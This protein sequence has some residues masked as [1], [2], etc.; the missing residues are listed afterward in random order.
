MSTGVQMQP[1]ERKSGEICDGSGVYDELKF[2]YCSG[3][4]FTR[5]G[6]YGVL[7]LVDKL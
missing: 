2:T 3:T 4:T 7:L 6:T 1:S 5:G